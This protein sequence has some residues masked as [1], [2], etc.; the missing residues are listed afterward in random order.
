[1]RN[2]TF[3]L[4]LTTH[5]RKRKHINIQQF[6][7]HYNNMNAERFSSMNLQ[8]EEKGEKRTLKPLL[9][10]TVHIHVVYSLF[11]RYRSTHPSFHQHLRFP[12]WHVLTF[13]FLSLSSK[14]FCWRRKLSVLI[15]IFFIHPFHRPFYSRFYL[16]FRVLTLL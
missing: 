4:A 14:A 10:Y 5:R 7:H 13:E 11:L 6:K 3:F 1:M 15:L 12:I 2:D 9:L 16:L 8:K